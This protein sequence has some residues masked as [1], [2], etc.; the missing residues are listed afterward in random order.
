MNDDELN[1][2]IAALVRTATTPPSLGRWRHDARPRP[3]SAGPGGFWKRQILGPLK[4]GVVAV[5]AA[6]LATATVSVA[7]VVR[8]QATPPSSPA[9]GALLPATPA[10]TP[11]PVPTAPPTAASTAPPPRSAPQTTA[12]RP[13]AVPST[14]ATTPAPALPA[15]PHAPL[16]TSDGHGG[17]NVSGSGS[18]WWHLGYGTTGSGPAKTYSYPDIA[19][20][21][22]D[23]S[24]PPGVRCLSVQPVQG[25]D[26][27]PGHPGRTY[28]SW[29]N[30]FCN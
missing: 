28:G 6:A 21:T 5:A 18:D 22:T 3:A 23:V 26:A 7:L 16:I 1:Q 12:L 8:H 30:W 4:S 10:A 25:G 14:A 13:T 20:T 29:S 17:F 27:Y 19:A 24:L 2:Q 9:T 11:S 15:F